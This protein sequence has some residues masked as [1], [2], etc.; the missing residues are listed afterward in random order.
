MLIAYQQHVE[1]AWDLTI[2]KSAILTQEWWMWLNRYKTHGVE[3]SHITSHP[4]NASAH[5]VLCQVDST[6]C[7]LRTRCWHP[8]ALRRGCPGWRKGQKLRG[9]R[10]H[11]HQSLFL[12]CDANQSFFT[13]PCSYFR[14]LVYLFHASHLEKSFSPGKRQFETHLLDGT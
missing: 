2:S 10:S 8:R 6:K 13:W 3:F 5:C 7:W 14:A 4:R 11:A 1:E 12:S 9:F